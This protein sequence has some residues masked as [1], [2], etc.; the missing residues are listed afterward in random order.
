MIFRTLRTYLVTI[1]V[2][3]L[4]FWLVSHAV[5]RLFGWEW[6][7]SRFCLTYGILMALLDIGQK[8]FARRGRKK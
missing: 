6:V 3:A 7:E 5:R 2:Y 4:L 1:L 8:H